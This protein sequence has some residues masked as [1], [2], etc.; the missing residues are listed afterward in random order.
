M[1]AT[2]EASP[3][4]PAPLTSPDNRSISRVQVIPPHKPTEALLRESVGRE[5]A[6]AGGKEMSDRVEPAPVASVPRHSGPDYA[7][8]EEG[9]PASRPVEGARPRIPVQDRNYVTLSTEGAQIRLV[10]VRVLGFDVTRSV[11]PHR[12][13][14][15]S[16]VSLAPIPE[17]RETF[18]QFVGVLQ[19]LQQG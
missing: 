17:V 3:K 16:V 14:D 7:P 2:E 4:R 15:E 12:H 10:G 13:V 5:T 11:G 18:D 6:H 1:G 19:F 8:S 9:L